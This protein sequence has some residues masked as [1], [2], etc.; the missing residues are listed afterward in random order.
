MVQNLCLSLDL[1]STVKLKNQPQFLVQCHF[2]LVVLHSFQ[3]QM[4]KQRTNSNNNKNWNIRKGVDTIPVRCF[5]VRTK[6]PESLVCSCQSY[7]TSI[8]KNAIH[9]DISS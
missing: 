7:A 6:C 2:Y 5:L 3:E 1:I 8:H 4:C 9:T